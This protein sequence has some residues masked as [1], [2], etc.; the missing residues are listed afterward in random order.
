MWGPQHLTTLWG[1]MACYRDSFTFT[2][3]GILPRQHSELMGARFKM[4]CNTITNSTSF[5]C[6]DTY[7][8][9]NDGQGASGGW[10]NYSPTLLWK[11]LHKNDTFSLKCL[12]GAWEFQ[13]VGYQIIRTLLYNVLYCGLLAMTLYGPVDGIVNSFSK[14][15]P[16]KNIS[17]KEN[18]TLKQRLHLRQYSN[19]HPH[20]MRPI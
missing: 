2:F 1:F 20:L 11:S 9:E 18:H 5:Y 17:H 4:Y 14:I 12:P 13:M 19:H 16:Q 15:Q 6:N 3:Y 8:R 7:I 10:E